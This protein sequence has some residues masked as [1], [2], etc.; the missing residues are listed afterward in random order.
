MQVVAQLTVPSGHDAIMVEM[1]VQG[2]S[3]DADDYDESLTWSIM[4]TKSAWSSTQE[5]MGA[6]SG[7]SGTPAAS[8]ADDPDFV[9]AQYGSTCDTFAE[10]A[11]NSNHQYCTEDADSSGRLAAEACPVACGSCTLQRTLSPAA[12]LSD[13]HDQACALSESIGKSGGS[14]DRLLSTT[15]VPPLSFSTYR[16]TFASVQS[17]GDTLKQSLN[18]LSVSSDFQA[19]FSRADSLSEADSIDEQGLWQDKIDADADRM[20]VY[21]T[22]IQGIEATLQQTLQSMQLNGPSLIESVVGQL[23]TAQQDFRRAVSVEALRAEERTLLELTV[24]DI[25]SQQALIQQQ[26]TGLSTDA[27]DR[28]RLEHQL[29]SLTQQQ[30]LVQQRLDDDDAPG[31]AG[32]EGGPVGGPTCS[33]SCEG[34]VQP[35]SNGCGND[36]TGLFNSW[37]MRA[38]QTTTGCSSVPYVMNHMEPCCDAHDICYGTCGVTQSFCDQ[39]LRN[40][41]QSQAS[42]PECQTTVDASGLTVQLLGCNHFIDAQTESVSPSCHNTDENQ[43]CV[44]SCRDEGTCIQVAERVCDTVGAIAGAVAAYHVPVVSQLAGTVQQVTGVASYALSVVDEAWDAV[45]SWFGRRLQACGDMDPAECQAMQQRITAL[46]DK[47]QAAKRLVATASSLAAL[48]TQLLAPDE[49]DHAALAKLDMSFLDVE[50]LNDQV[51]VDAF[52]SALGSSAA[53]YE[54]ELRQL[55]TLTRSKLEQMRAYYMAALSKRVNEEQRDLLGRRAERAS[56]LVADEADAVAQLGITQGFL[57][58]KLR[59]YSHVGLQ[60]VIQGARA[61]EYLF[62]EPYT[63]LDLDRLRSAPIS[64][65]EYYDFVTQA[66]TDL[67]STFTRTASRFNNAGGSTYASTVFTLADLPAAQANFARTGE[68]T[69]S[70]SMPSESNY[71]G[72]TFSDVRA[73][74]VGLPTRGRTPVTIDLVKK[75][76]SVFKDARGDTHRFTH[77]DTNPPLRFIYEAQTCATISTSDGQLQSGNMEDIYVRY[78]PY[79]TWELQVH[80]GRA[81]TLA[82]A[83][84]TAI[85]FEF[86]LQSQPGRFDGSPIFFNH[87]KSL[88]GELGADACIEDDAAS[89]G[90]SGT[91]ICV[92]DIA[93]RYRETIRGRTIEYTC[94]DFVASPELGVGSCEESWAVGTDSNHNEVTPY[95]A[96]ELSCPLTSTMRSCT[97]PSLNIC[98]DD[99][100]WRYVESYRGQTTEYTCAEFVASPDH[101]VRSCGESWAVGLN[102]EGI[103][104]TPYAACE[105]ACVLDT[106]MN[107]QTRT[108]TQSTQSAA[109][110]AR[111]PACNN[112][113]Q[114]SQAMSPVNRVCC[115]E[116]SEDCSSGYPSSCN[117]DCAAMLLPAQAA[118]EDFLA[119][120]GAALAPV[121]QLIDHASAL[122]PSESASHSHP[123][124]DINGDG[125]ISVPD[126]LLFLAA[127]GQPVSVLHVYDGLPH[128]ADTVGVADLLLMLEDFGKEP[129]AGCIGP[130]IGEASEFLDVVVAASAS[131]TSGYTTYRL[132]VSLHGTARSLYS[133]EGTPEGTMEL[134]AAYQAVPPF[135]ADVGGVNPQ[136]YTF[137]ADAEFDS[138]LSVGITDGD[139]ARELSTIGIDFATWT[140]SV[141]LSVDNGAVFWLDP[142]DA[143]GGHVVV[144]QLTVASGSSGTV[145]MGMQGHSTEGD[146]WDARRV[147]FTYP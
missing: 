133:I 28:G 102:S 131:S 115:D 55:T 32:L 99:P 98:A 53:T 104:V 84:V 30:S 100:G 12:A 41:M 85:R 70:I 76:T 4:G 29:Q 135:G 137:M 129:S 35:S 93:W 86:R 110:D 60:Y 64:G 11:R 66:E 114:F 118:C 138:W 13:M 94:A 8:C 125:Q 48:N 124:M 40:C 67:Q 69:L 101:G 25:A 80:P 27:L 79:G 126:L 95:Q 111:P 89:S 57:D 50:L 15:D 39:Q 37:A 24:R 54:T 5:S 68:I 56:Q 2:H 116:P 92:D 38:L 73:F 128:A 87:G 46:Q 42:L 62:L 26:I 91:N 117:A 147:V 134:P 65:S 43:G 58:A 59:A 127:F 14:V 139:V 106:S 88:L 136:F 19:T 20:E 23:T 145:T 96:C 74:L 3:I 52:E 130:I 72:V 63:G 10:G 71:Y 107:P 132:T 105:V 17:Y 82:L 31:A 146:D 6:V 109:T 142:N 36:F 18:I 45:S 47:M 90:T 22:Q 7:S 141:G 123:C 75:G 121:K 97:P 77:D 78:S 144:V 103:E 34:P 108:C 113:A 83:E 49:I 122:C 143:P 16:D 112:I 119:G 21:R 51:L 120:A 9:D 44:A 61:Y 33:E 1:S 81:V 140:D